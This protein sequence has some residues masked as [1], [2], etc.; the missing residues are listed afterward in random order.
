MSRKRDIGHDGIQEEILRK[1]E[2]SSTQRQIDIGGGVVVNITQEDYGK[3]FIYSPFL[4]LFW[5]LLYSVCYRENITISSRIIAA[6][7]LQEGLLQLLEFIYVFEWLLMQ[8]SNVGLVFSDSNYY[9]A[10]ALKNAE[11]AY[12]IHQ[13]RVCIFLIH[14]VE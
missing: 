7:P 14:E 10:Q 11:D 9:K 12:Q 8:S 5:N 1:L 3:W 2:D 13:A 4:A 6:V